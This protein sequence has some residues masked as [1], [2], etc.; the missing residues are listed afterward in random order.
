MFVR[1]CFCP[2]V[3][4]TELGRASAAY[5]AQY[6][7]TPHHL[8]YTDALFLSVFSNPLHLLAVSFICCYHWAC[9][10]RSL[11]SS[12]SPHLRAVATKCLR[13]GWHQRSLHPQCA[14]RRT[15]PVLRVRTSLVDV[16]VAVHND[17]SAWMRSVKLP[18][19]CAGQLPA[20]ARRMCLAYLN[21]VEF[22]AHPCK[23]KC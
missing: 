12:H 8:Y 16:L 21:A 7:D 1:N 18:S 20:P 5:R 13:P 22:A 17:E 11:C 2:A 9:I 23:C 14:V 3:L 4:V 6:I 19:L 15:S 10:H